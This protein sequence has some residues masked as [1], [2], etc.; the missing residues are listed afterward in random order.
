MQLTELTLTN[1]RS[2]ESAHIFPHGLLNVLLGANGQ[3]KTNLM[4][5][6][7][8][9]CNG[10]NFRGNKDTELIR[11]EA[12][13]LRVQGAFRL[14]GSRR[15]Y[16]ETLYADSARKKSMVLNGV[17]Y[18]R[19]SQLP[20]RLRAVLFTPDDLAVIKGAPAERRRFLDDELAN[21][22]ESDLL[23]RRNYEK[24]LSQRN[25]LLREIRTRRARREELEVWNVQLVRYGTALIL[26]RLALLRV[27]VPRARRIHARLCGADRHFDVTYQSSLGAA[28]DE[29]ALQACFFEQLRAH[30]EE[31][32]ARGVSL[33]GPHRDDLLFYE[34]GADLR[35]FGSQG[36]Q[37]TAVLAMKTAV[38]D[39]I[40]SRFEERPLFLLDDVM[41]E[42]DAERQ[43]AV[44]DIVLEKRIQT[45]LTGTAIDLPAGLDYDPVFLVQGG[46]VSPRAG[47]RPPAST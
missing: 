37:R 41:S 6:V 23:L 45:F 10:H 15:L 32:V 20:Q 9:L 26:H 28:G 4:E 47:H 44:M 33:F 29:T 14:E 19:V 7:W 18:R 43:R 30:E 11:W 13:F 12:P 42:L 34:A 8:Y 40:E 36:Q 31:E 16:Q 21:L 22:D 38:L 35:V 17:R 25:E 27:L 24:I 5:A 46:T 2:Y 1:W 39:V 3:G